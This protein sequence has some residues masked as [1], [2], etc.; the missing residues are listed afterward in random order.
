[1]NNLTETK[2]NKSLSKNIE[3]DF[4]FDKV[5]IIDDNNSISEVIP[6]LAQYENEEN[7]HSVKLIFIKNNHF[8]EDILLLSNFVKGSNMNFASEILTN[9]V[10]LKA[11]AAA[12]AGTKGK[13]RINKNSSFTM[14]CYPPLADYELDDIVEIISL[15]TKYKAEDIINDYF[16]KKYFSAEDLSNVIPFEYF[17]DINIFH[18]NEKNNS[19][20]EIRKE[21]KK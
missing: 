13:I 8:P 6:R 3:K 10:D 14:D 20:S 19:L 7:V 2:G 11:L 15:K 17:E 12:I 5:V 4:P 16:E 1:M 18:E 9:N 21:T